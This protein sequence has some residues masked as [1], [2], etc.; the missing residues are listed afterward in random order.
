ML[1]EGVR[2]LLQ[3]HLGL[4][5]CRSIFGRNTR[6]LQPSPL[7]RSI[8]GKKQPQRQHDSYFASRKGQRHQRLAIGGLAPH[9]NH[10]PTSFKR[11]DPIGPMTHHYSALSEIFCPIV[12]GPHGVAL[13]VGKL[14]LDHIR[15]KAHFVESGRQRAL[16]GVLFGGS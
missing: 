9:W 5:P 14:A 11:V 10:R 8:L 4:C 12:G 6:S 2:D 1:E 7:A 16:S 3:R 13:F 15:P